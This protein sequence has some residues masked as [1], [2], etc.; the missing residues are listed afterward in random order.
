MGWDIQFLL[1]FI[2]VFL[3]ALTLHEFAHAWTA[4]Q[5]GDTT[6][7]WAGRVTL[8]PLKH[9]DP[10]GTL[11]M[12]MVHFGWAKPVP[13]NPANFTHPHAGL[14]VSLAGIVAN[15]VQAALYAVAWHALQ[16][17]MPTALLGRGFV[18]TLLLLGVMVNLSLA[19]FNLLP[20]FPLDG[21]HVVENLLPK[22]Q[23]YR[24]SLLSQRYGTTILL[25]L[26]F[27]GYVSTPAPLSLL[28]E[29]PRTWL[30]HV[31]LSGF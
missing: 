27:L 12:F 4:L 18:A 5:F 25:G 23:A 22:R 24:F 14:W 15:L 13:V 2:P 17:F 31:L 29:V 21:S 10:L 11:F 8:N 3:F 7:Q 6:A 26:L 19:L 20:L 28:I 9:L 16:Y 30:A 1:P